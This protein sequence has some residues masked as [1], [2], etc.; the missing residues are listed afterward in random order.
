MCGYEVIDGKTL[1]FAICDEFCVAISR[2]FPYITLHS[3]RL[4]I[5]IVFVVIVMVIEDGE[6]NLIMMMCS[7]ERTVPLFDK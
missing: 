2:K 7:Y 6:S 4:L 1:K 3:S 5:V